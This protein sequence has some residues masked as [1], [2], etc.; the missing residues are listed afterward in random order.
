MV[1]ALAVLLALPAH[2]G[3]EGS[4]PDRGDAEHMRISGEIE[5]LAERQVWSGVEKKFR[6]LEKLGVELSYDDMMHGAYAARA[7]GE[8]SGAYER[9]K[10]AAR[11]DS[12]KEVIDWLYAIDMNYSSV[13]LVAVPPRYVVLTV[14][15]MPFDPDQR[16]AVE[17]AQAT[18]ADRGLYAG[19]LPR[20][21]YVFA[22]QPFAVQPGI[23]VRIEVSPRIK[24]TEG[25][26]V[27][28]QKSPVWG[29]SDGSTPASS[30]DS[31]AG[32]SPQ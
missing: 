26:R 3:G 25:I 32:G 11:I 23:G 12:T 21:N 13:D 6:E 9:L 20:G 28:L 5:Q 4:S 22:G 31:A 14:E 7:L 8:M 17:K 27:E 10:K 18:V 16:T 1:L 29:S 15:E 30:P 24:K 2:A 19:L